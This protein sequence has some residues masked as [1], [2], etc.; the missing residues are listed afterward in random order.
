MEINLKQRV[1]NFLKR[2]WIHKEEGK[3]TFVQLFGFLLIT[4][5]VIYFASF[6]LPSGIIN[7]FPFLKLAEHPESSEVPIAFFTIMLGVA[8]AF[9]SMLKGQTKDM[10][11]MRIIIFMFANVI[12]MLLLKIGWDKDTLSEIGLNSYWMG[13]IAFLFGGKATQ[14]YFESKMAVPAQSS[15]DGMSAIKFSESDIARLAITQNEQYLKAKFPNILSISDAVNDINNEE[16]HIIVIYLRDNNDESLPKKLEVKMPDNSIKLI[17]T[18]VIK[19]VGKGK[20]HFAQYDN[21]QMDIDNIKIYGSFCCMVKTPNNESALVTAAHIYSNGFSNIT[22]GWLTGAQKAVKIKDENIGTW[23]FA[24]I[25][26]NQDIGLIKLNDFKEDPEFLKFG[27]TGIYEIKDKDVKNEK[28]TL[29]SGIKGKREGYILDYNTS[30]EVPYND[31]APIK[32]GII[33]IGSVNN[34][35]DSV[36][37]SEKGDS[38]GCVYHT[39]SKKLVG[40]ILGGNEKYTWVLPVKETFDYWELKLI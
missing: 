20:I 31:Y 39:E 24:L 13:V 19:G 36:T 22:N 32:T 12:C 30:W 4:L 21:L 29:V 27:T 26:Q 25:T 40:L 10:S 11:T 6:L 23:M 37:L 2:D 28:V 14:S 1:N 9:P 35:Q 15:K 16:T 18:E 38:G 5:G 17:S 7:I 3:L 8:F 34:R 33:L